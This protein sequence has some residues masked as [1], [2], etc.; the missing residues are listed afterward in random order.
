VK[1]E[2]TN[3]TTYRPAPGDLVLAFHR[4]LVSS[5]TPVLGLRL[6]RYNWNVEILPNTPVLV[7]EATSGGATVLVLHKGELIEILLSDVVPANGKS[8]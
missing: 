1:N 3:H 2:I 5:T 4:S 8:Q 7:V 6:G